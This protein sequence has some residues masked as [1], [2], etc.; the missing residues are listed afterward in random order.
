LFTEEKGGGTYD[1]GVGKS[2][3]K[4][5]L[6]GSVAIFGLSDET[7]ASVIVGS[8]FPTLHTDQRNVLCP[9]SPETERV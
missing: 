6:G 3:D 7:L 1:S 5:V 2:H 4:A 9:L 8:A